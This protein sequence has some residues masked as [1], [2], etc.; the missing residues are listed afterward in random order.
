MLTLHKEKKTKRKKEKLLMP[1]LTGRDEA[2]NERK[3]GD[4]G[5]KWRDGLWVEAKEG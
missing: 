1:I 3:R 5:D 4:E 2:R